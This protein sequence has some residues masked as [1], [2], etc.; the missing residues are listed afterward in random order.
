MKV[1]FNGTPI[2]RGQYGVVADFQ[3]SVPV[4]SVTATGLAREAIAVDFDWL[5][6]G[7][8]TERLDLQLNGVPT[9]PGSSMVRS[10]YDFTSGLRSERTEP[11]FSISDLLAV[12]GGAKARGC[13]Y[14]LA[15][16][17][18][19]QPIY[20]ECEGYEEDVNLVLADRIRYSSRRGKWNSAAQQMVNVVTVATATG[21][22]MIDAGSRIVVFG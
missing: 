4:A 10:Q 6:A 21:R 1:N 3:V 22:S 14:V 12:L 2:R 13:A 11:A 20:V 5:H 18:Y 15:E 9:P 17:D 16:Q 19:V 7:T 8:L